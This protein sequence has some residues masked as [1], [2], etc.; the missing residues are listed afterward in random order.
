M[1]ETE[2]QQLTYKAMNDLVNSAN[3][4]FPLYHGTDLRIA[5]MSKEERA[6]FRTDCEKTVE[7]LWNVYKPY[8]D[9]NYFPRD[10][11]KELFKGD[12]N[13]TRW[14]NLCNALT[15]YSAR[16]NG[17]VQYQYD[18]F[19]LTNFR[20]I[21][22]DYA[23]SSFAFGEIGLLP[24]RM[25]DAM[26]VLQ[27]PEWS[28]NKEVADALNRIV[29]FAEDA[30]HACPVIFE[31]Y[32]LDF[33]HIEIERGGSVWDYLL[34]RGNFSHAASIVVHYS[35]EMQLDPVKAIYLK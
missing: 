17:N 27:F 29:D 6:S 22:E 11:F 24:F 19:Y 12:K 13:K 2:K 33:N 35:G 14:Y 7:A 16:L 1:E 30:D 31:I 28:P 15:C 20:E 34:Q 5:K 26:R 25:F 3:T 21:A 32:N 10:T 4:L 8:L 9:A 23:R 18:C